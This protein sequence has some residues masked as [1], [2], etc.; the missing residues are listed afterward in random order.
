MVPRASR[1][2]TDEHGRASLEELAQDCERRL[3][4]L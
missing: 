4:Q 1:G 3:N 2:C